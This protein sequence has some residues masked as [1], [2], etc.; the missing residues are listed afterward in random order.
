MGDSGPPVEPSCITGAA[1][2]AASVAPS[3]SVLAPG[4]RQ[5]HYKV[6]DQPPSETPT[7]RRAQGSNL[8]GNSSQA[9]YSCTYLISVLVYISKYY[10]CLVQH[11]PIRFFIIQ[12][13]M[14]KTTGPSAKVIKFNAALGAAAAG[15]A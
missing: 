3:G 13:W 10:A 1:A 2:A 9:S 12:R 11:R 7:R 5:K 15:Y 14:E 8:R 6:D 4:A